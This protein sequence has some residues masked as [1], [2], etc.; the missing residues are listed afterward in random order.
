MSISFEKYNPKSYIVKGLVIS[1][2][3]DRQKL[4]SK[5]S[6]KCVFNTRLKGGSGLIVPINDSNTKVLS[7]LSLNSKDNSDNTSLSSVIV[8]YENNKKEDLDDLLI[9]LINENDNVTIDEKNNTTNLK[10]KPKE[11]QVSIREN[12]FLSKNSKMSNTRTKKEQD[13][14]SLDQRNDNRFK[15]RVSRESRE[16]RESR[17][18]R[19]SREKR[20]NKKRGRYSNNSSDESSESESSEYS[21]DSSEDERIKYT[22][23]KKGQRPNRKMIEKSDSDVDSDNEDVV[24]LSRRVRYLIRKIKSIEEFLRK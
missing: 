14:S 2:L 1:S 10:M 19:D 12:N 11:K 4:I 8:P 5:L 18:P 6:G 16:S 23:R 20:E 24:T 3:P 22:L 9:K 21:G 7:E 13:N 15:E 17:D